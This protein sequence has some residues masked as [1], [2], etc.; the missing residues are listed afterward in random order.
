MTFF[1]YFCPLLISFV[2]VFLSAYLPMSFLP[3]LYLLVILSE[4]LVMFF[5]ITKNVHRY[6]LT[7]K[8]KNNFETILSRNYH[9][10]YMEPKEKT[11]RKK[12]KKTFFFYLSSGTTIETLTLLLPP[13]SPSP[14]TTTTTMLSSEP[15]SIG[16]G[17]INVFF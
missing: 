6:L 14:K 11:K 2:R 17:N 10:V 7:L 8:K 4:F 3:V 15:A 9:S 12:N 5:Y 1:V 16:K 13:V